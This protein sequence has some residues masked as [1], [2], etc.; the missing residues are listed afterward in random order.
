MCLLCVVP[1]DF[2][3]PVFV[4]FEILFFLSNAGS[5]GGREI[6]ENSEGAG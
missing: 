3:S 6:V 5:C 4:K 1:K 2:I